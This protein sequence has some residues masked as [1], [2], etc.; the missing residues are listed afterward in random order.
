MI[1]KDVYQIETSQ[2]ENIVQTSADLQLYG[3]VSGKLVK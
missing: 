3:I 1:S 2:K